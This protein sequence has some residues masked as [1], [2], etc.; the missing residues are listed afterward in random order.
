MKF[1]S[2]KE[3]W[4]GRNNWSE[5]FKEY[6]SIQEN[7]NNVSKYWE[8]PKTDNLEDFYKEFNKRHY[9]PDWKEYISIERALIHATGEM[10]VSTIYT[11]MAE[12]TAMNKPPLAKVY[13]T[14]DDLSH[15]LKPGASKCLLDIL[16]GN[17]IDMPDVGILALFIHHGATNFDEMMRI[18][19]DSEYTDSIE[20]L[21]P[22][23]KQKVDYS[24]IKNQVYKL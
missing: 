11:L 14:E 7:R 8:F 10:L 22:Y 6:I 15:H 21:K 4:A 13:Y 2:N 19:V 23:C 5:D 20:F 24:A 16:V 12:Y 18:A 1:D 3:L 9:T 17:V